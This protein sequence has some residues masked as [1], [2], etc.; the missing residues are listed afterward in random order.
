[1]L[2]IDDLTTLPEAR[3]KG[4]AAGLLDWLIAHDGATDCDAV[5][6]D[7]GYGRHVAHRLYLSHGF[8]LAC[9]RMAKDLR[10]PLR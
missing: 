6:L 9:H 10:Q 5:P 2:Y 1:M 4:F 8:E 7:T 3:G